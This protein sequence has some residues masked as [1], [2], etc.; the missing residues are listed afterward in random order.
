MSSSTSN[1]IDQWLKTLATL[2][3]E[4]CVK[5]IVSQFPRINVGQLD[6]DLLLDL[7]IRLGELIDQLVADSEYPL[8]NY[9]HAQQLAS[10]IVVM[11]DSLS[12]FMSK[13]GPD[14]IKATITISW[15]YGLLLRC[16][17]VNFLANPKGYWRRLHE[18]YDHA[19]RFLRRLKDDGQEAS[20]TVATHYKQCLLFERTVPNKLLAHEQHDIWRLSKEVAE[21]LP[22]MMGLN[23][24]LINTTGDSA[25]I[26]GDK[27]GLRLNISRA[28][29]IVNRLSCSDHLKKKLNTLI[30]ERKERSD[31]RVLFEGKIKVAAGLENIHKALTKGMSFGSFIRHAPNPASF[32]SSSVFDGV[33]PTNNTSL[34]ATDYTPDQFMGRIVDR[35]KQG[36]KLIAQCEKAHSCRVNDILLCQTPKNERFAA[37]TKW[38]TEEDHDRIFG[39]QV[40]HKI[41]PIAV[42][43]ANKVGANSDWLPAL[44]HGRGR[45]IVL[46]GYLIEDNQVLWVYGAGYFQR[47][48]VSQILT[49]TGNQTLVKG[50]FLQI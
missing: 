19:T 13:P 1:T 33:D 3:V 16:V 41:E 22:L 2:P 38:L 48:K 43:I 11:I 8:E 17:H 23:G 37:F 49:E 32:N 46:P 18:H 30:C 44:L 14:S 26:M 21:Q 40:T 25:F 24:E 28:E 39:M 47:W 50:N 7:C 42:S 31:S 36:L 10:N 6:D 35:S 27:S 9:A 29:Q 12:K 20:K 45:S 4:A 15:L 34:S 5:H